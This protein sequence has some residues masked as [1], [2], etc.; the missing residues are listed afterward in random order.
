MGLRR[1]KKK[2]LVWAVVFFIPL[3]GAGFFF[4]RAPVLIVSDTFFDLLYGPRRTWERRLVLS[5]RFFRPIKTV[6]IGE[7]AGQDMVP[8]AVE[9]ASARPHAVF[10][11]FRYGEGAGRYVRQHPDIPTVVLG[12]R[13]P[14]PTEEN[15]LFFGTDT[16][17]DMYRAG[18]CAA[19]LIRPDEEVFV[20]PDSL[21]TGADR[22]A[23][24]EGLRTGGYTKDPLYMNAYAD[25]SSRTGIAV[26]M[27][28]TP[29]SFLDSGIKIPVILFSWMDPALTSR[30]VKL[31]FDD[32]PWALALE[33]VK[34]LEGGGKEG[35]V[36]SKIS[37]FNR[38]LQER[39]LG[40]AI[41]N[42]TRQAR[43][44]PES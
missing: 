38:R 8:F 43:I 6:L 30:D 44:A 42:L 32:S 2:L 23:F 41:R 37:I 14:P 40:T 5:L 4:L 22:E 34:L 27:N 36:P 1:H 25:L 31:V 29:P 19:A 15:L 3:L 10:F 16:P 12:G 33:A 35:V 13:A 11:P 7:N 17:L 9:T 18:L 21:V 20:F 28:G 39:S 26:V 24:V